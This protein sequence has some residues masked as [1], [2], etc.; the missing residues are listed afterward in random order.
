MTAQVCKYNSPNSFDSEKT[1]RF[2]NV[3]KYR[4][5]LRKAQA[6]LDKWAKTRLG[7]PYDLALEV[8]RFKQKITDN[9][10]RPC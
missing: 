3:V 5:Q 6:N 10:D 1:R 8:Q 4:K 9:L 2:K 7:N